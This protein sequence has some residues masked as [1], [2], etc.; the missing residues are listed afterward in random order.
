[1]VIIKWIQS[2]HVIKWHKARHRNEVQNLS[3]LRESG[4]L[5]ISGLISP[6]DV[7]TKQLVFLGVNISKSKNLFKKAEQI[8]T[9]KNVLSVCI[10]SGRYDMIVE[11]WVDVKFGMID[12]LSKQLATVT[13][14]ASTESF[15]VMK[16][17]DKYIAVNK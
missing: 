10:T 3:K 15:L 17:C 4:L 2:S 9:L 7:D 13:E 12:F 8:S 1:V 6:D 16:S 14:I 5:T 11:V